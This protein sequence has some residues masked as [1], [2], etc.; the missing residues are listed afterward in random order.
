MGLPDNFSNTMNTIGAA[1]A[2]KPA[3]TVVGKS[4]GDFVRS[5]TGTSGIDSALSAHADEKHP[6]PK[7]KPV[8]GADWD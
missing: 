2:K 4:P 3:A 1:L 5:T 8:Y 6:V 7:R